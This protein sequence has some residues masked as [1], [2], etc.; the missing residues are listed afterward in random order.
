MAAAGILLF[1]ALWITFFSMA[2]DASLATDV[3]AEAPCVTT[4]TRQLTVLQQ[5]ESSKP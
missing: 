3:D 4:A 5:M 1:M 2:Q